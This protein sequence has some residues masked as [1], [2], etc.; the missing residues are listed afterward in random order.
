[1]IVS[2][3]ISVAGQKKGAKTR[4]KK[5]R[6]TRIVRLSFRSKRQTRPKCFLLCCRWSFLVHHRPSNVARAAGLYCVKVEQ[7]PRYAS[8]EDPRERVKS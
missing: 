4:P 7:K 1:M 5:Q 8:P 3:A 6:T 2:G